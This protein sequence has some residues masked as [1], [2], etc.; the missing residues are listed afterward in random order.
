MRSW[1][2]FHDARHGINRALEAGRDFD[3]LLDKQQRR[4]TWLDDH[5]SEVGWVTELETR[6]SETESAYQSRVTERESTRAS[7]SSTS[8]EEK[9]LEIAASSA[10][11]Q[12]VL[13]E[14]SWSV[15]R[16]HAGYV[17]APDPLPTMGGPKG[18]TLS[19]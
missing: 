5:P 1:N 16:E 11:R 4:A 19:R 15:E 8:R 17:E 3:S 13:I 9:D 14:D 18:P 12:R 6:L 7:R 2:E 10:A